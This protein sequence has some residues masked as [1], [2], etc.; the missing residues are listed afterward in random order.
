MC[1]VKSVLCLSS[2]LAGLAVPVA[3][4]QPSPDILT[5]WDQ[6]SISNAIASKCVKP[7]G[8]KLARFLLNYQIVSTH[9]S[10]KLSQT[11]KDWTPERIDRAMKERYV[12]ID[13]AMAAA[14]AQETCQGPK[15]MEALKRF[16]MQAGLDFSTA[17][18][19]K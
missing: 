17:K 18:D 5:I 16:D 15:I 10:L 9:A 7:D 14:I 13:Q 8:N 12:Q 1:T 6:F 11:S 4:E 19:A 2:L 3:A